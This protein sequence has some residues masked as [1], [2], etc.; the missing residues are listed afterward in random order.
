M[1]STKMEN[2]QWL[3]GIRHFFGR[4]FFSDP[5]TLLGLWLIL[6]VG[7]HW[8]R[9]TSAITSWYSSMFSGMLGIRLHCM[10]SIL[11][12]FSIRT[13]M[14]RSSASSSHLLPCCPIRWDYFSGKCWWRWLCLLPYANYRC[15]RASRY[16]AIGSVPMSCSRH[17]LWVSL[18]SSL[19]PSSS[20]RSIA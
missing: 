9:F 10:P 3:A 2:S 16:S 12:S 14:V 8:S 1:D 18:T 17:C 7:L 6:G 5:R 19:P 4:P 13:T 11:W 20:H 15:V